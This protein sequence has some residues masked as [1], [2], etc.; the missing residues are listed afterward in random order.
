[1]GKLSVPQTLD[2]YVYCV[3][4]PLRFTDPTGEWSLSKWWD[5]HWKEVAIVALCVAVVVTA[6]IAAPLVIAGVSTALM[7]SAITV[8][9]S[10][11]V[12]SAFISAGISATATYALSGGKA[13][14]SQI[15]GSFVFGGVAGAFLPGIGGM[16]SKGSFLGAFV[17]GGISGLM[18]NVY[19]E[20]TRNIAGMGAERN[21]VPSY[22]PRG[23]AVDVLFGAATAL[24]PGGEYVGGRASG[25][26]VPRN[27]YWQ[28][29]MEGF[30]TKR[31]PLRA[32]YNPLKPSGRYFYA[33]TAFDA[34]TNALIDWL[35]LPK[36]LS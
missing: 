8:S 31:G 15:M 30:F 1:M 36:Y 26:G 12:A 2:R 3:N 4:N 7:G 34:G 23:T 11:S 33:S 24:I 10:V 29:S 32:I 9:A 19:G 6:G 27:Y 21:S 35:H 5:K 14:F 16:L 22:D 28:I 17:L 25:I 13:S 18:G 20:A